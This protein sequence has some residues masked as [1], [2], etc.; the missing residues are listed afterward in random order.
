MI[1]GANAMRAVP[2]GTCSSQ[3]TQARKKGLAQPERRVGGAMS[4]Q[5]RRR[6]EAPRARTKCDIAISHSRQRAAKKQALGDGA[7]TP[8][9]MHQS[10]A[11]RG[12]VSAFISLR[13]RE[14]ESGDGS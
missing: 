9:S 2:T 13:G 6:G 10:T 8:A 12:V 1:S 4:R 11:C 3:S 5:R 14:R 7:C